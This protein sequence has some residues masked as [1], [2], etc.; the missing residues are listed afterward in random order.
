[1]ALTSIFLSTIKL[2]KE[3]R[4][5]IFKEIKLNRSG[6]VYYYTEAC[7]PELNEPEHKKARID[8]L[9]IVVVKGVIVDAAFFEM[10]N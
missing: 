3:Y 1:M 10:K 7:F 4:D 9:I 6:K 8:G 5:S 2:V